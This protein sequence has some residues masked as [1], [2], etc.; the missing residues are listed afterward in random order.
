MKKLI[1]ILL[2]LPLLFSTC[3]KEDEEPTNSGNNNNSALSIG[4]MHQG[5]IVFYL[6]GN[7]GGL[8]A[9]LTDQS[10]TFNGSEWGC[11]G[12]L[13]GAD[14]MVVGTGSQNTIN[15]VNNNCSTIVYGMTIAANICSDLTIGGYSD[16]YLPSKDELNQMYLNRG[17]INTTATANG[18]YSLGAN[19]DTSSISS[20]WSSTEHD[21]NYAWRQYMIEGYQT[22]SYSKSAKCHVRAIRSF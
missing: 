11:E 19:N 13:L 5:G 7:G 10:P 22:Y 2:C 17:A 9:A 18:G 12:I 3:K 20:Y 15:I 16:W 4:D 1:L 21:N 14:G 8:I 6:D